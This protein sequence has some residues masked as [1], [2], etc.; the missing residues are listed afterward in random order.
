MLR[1]LDHLPD[2][3]EMVGH[4]AKV[5]LGC[6]APWSTVGITF[7]QSIPRGLGFFVRRFQIFESQLAR[8]GRR[9]SRPANSASNGTRDSRMTPSPT[10]GQAKPPCSSRL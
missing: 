10:L 4:N 3:R 7:D 6:R 2:E 8:I 9:Q 5:A 1:G